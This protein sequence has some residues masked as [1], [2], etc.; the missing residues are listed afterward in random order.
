MP[1]TKSDVEGFKKG[2]DAKGQAQWVAI[3]N[4]ALSD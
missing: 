4:S 3:A 1:W 2:L